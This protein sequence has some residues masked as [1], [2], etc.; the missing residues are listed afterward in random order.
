MTLSP[1]ITAKM[2][3]VSTHHVHTQTLLEMAADKTLSKNSR[4]KIRKDMRQIMEWRKQG[5]V[6][7]LSHVLPELQMY[8]VLGAFSSAN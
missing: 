5:E 2:S 1:H 7:E 3:R 6:L 8:V 4:V